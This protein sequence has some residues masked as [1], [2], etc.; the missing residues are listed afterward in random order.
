MSLRTAFLLAV[1]TGVITGA[2]VGRLREMGNSHEGHWI[3]QGAMLGG[4]AGAAIFCS[5]VVFNAV[6]YF[7]LGPTPPESMLKFSILA[8]IMFALVLALM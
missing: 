1:L 4:F 3:L 8:I 6:L 2:A 7:L 5:V